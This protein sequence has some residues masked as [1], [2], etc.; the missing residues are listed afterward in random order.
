MDRPVCLCL[1]RFTLHALLYEQLHCAVVTVQSAFALYNTMRIL[2][3][4]FDLS[5]LGGGKTSMYK[6]G[7]INKN[8]I[9]SY[10][11]KNNMSITKQ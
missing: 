11:S 2:F 1:A 4:D 7:S 9:I 8:P 10:R 3:L 6:M 5:S